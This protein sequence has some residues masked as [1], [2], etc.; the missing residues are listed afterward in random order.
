MCVYVHACVH[1]YE[2]EGMTLG[3]FLSCFYT[4]VFEAGSLTETR[5]CY[6]AR[7]SG[8]QALGLLLSQYPQC[9]AHRLMLPHLAFYIDYG[10]MNSV[11]HACETSTLLTEPA[12]S[13]SSRFWKIFLYLFNPFYVYECFACMHICTQHVCLLPQ[14]SEEGSRPPKIR[15]MNGTENW[16]RVV[17]KINKCS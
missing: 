7:L 9:C 14:R 11:N 17:Y 10:G 16:T 15:V 4:S 2:S 12:P 3:V 13:P 6:S 5:I 1:T 8:L